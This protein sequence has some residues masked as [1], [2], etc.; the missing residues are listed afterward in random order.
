MDKMDWSNDEITLL[1][2]EVARRSSVDPEFRDLALTNP[3]AAIAKV[4]T[5]PLPE[6]LDIKF[7]DNSGGTKYFPLPD[8]IPGL[9]ELS[10]AE[11]LAIA[12]GDVSTT[13]GIGHPPQGPTVSVAAGWRR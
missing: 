3:A 10:E 5:R 8:P 12:G 1:L 13:V 6:D 4:S 9:E 7:L 11:L 2:S